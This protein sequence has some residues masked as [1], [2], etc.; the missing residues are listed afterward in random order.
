MQAVAPEL[1]GKLF[2]CLAAGQDT[3][4]ALGGWEPAGW[5]ICSTGPKPHCGAAILN[6]RTFLSRGSHQL[7]FQQQTFPWH[8]Q[9]TRSGHTAARQHRQRDLGSCH[10]TSPVTEEGCAAQLLRERKGENPNASQ[11]E[12]AQTPPSPQIPL[13]PIQHRDTEGVQGHRTHSWELRVQ[14]R[15]SA[16]KMHGIHLFRLGHLQ[17]GDPGGF[18][19]ITGRHLTWIR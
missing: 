9:Q 7:T 13:G 8:P 16:S 17:F 15:F 4:S 10:P 12:S 3:R 6:T 19:S 5:D 1:P 18:T 2:V 11:Q 14:A